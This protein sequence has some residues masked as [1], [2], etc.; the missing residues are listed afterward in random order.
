MLLR[1]RTLLVTTGTCIMVLLS[2]C[3]TGPG[4]YQAADQVA[5]RHNW[6]QEIIATSRF[7]LLSYYR[8]SKTG[9]A[10]TIYIEGDGRAWRSKYRLSSDPTPGTPLV[11]KLAALDPSPNIAYLARPCQYVLQIGHDR[12]CRS[13]YWSSAR[14]NK[15]IVDAIN[16]AIT[17]LKNR[18]AASRLHLVGYSGGGALAILVAAG[19]DDIAS[20]RTVSGNLDHDEFTRY[21]RVIPLTE[22][23]NPVDFADAVSMLPQIHFSGA[24]DTIVPGFIA[25]KFVEKLEHSSCVALVAVEGASHDNGWLDRWPALLEHDPPCL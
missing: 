17:Y 10:L 21:H 15:E 3:A 6:Q 19:R 4:P 16:E 5:A 18:A 22:S 25:Q 20:L 14:F 2:G 23:L 9:N 11:L 1:L 7:D 24:K 12:N 13:E 8:F